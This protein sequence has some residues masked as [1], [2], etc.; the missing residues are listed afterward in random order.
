MVLVSIEKYLM[1]ATSA[2]TASNSVASLCF[3]IKPSLAIVPLLNNLIALVTSAF[4]S[5]SSE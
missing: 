4:I 1:L 3:T 2:S 5:L